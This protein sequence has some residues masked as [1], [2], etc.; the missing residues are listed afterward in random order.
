MT[1]RIH[2]GKQ[3]IRLGRFI[4]SLAPVVMRPDDLI[5]FSKQ[6]YHRAGSVEEW[7]NE[8]VVIGG[9]SPLEKEL[10]EQVP[11]K[12][13]RLLLLGLGG[14]REAIAFAHLGYEVLGVDYLAEMVAK[15]R[16]N[17]AKQ[18][19]SIQSRVQE[20]SRLEMPP[21]TFHLAVLFAAMYSMIPTRRRRVEMLRRIGRSLKPG[22]YL[23]CQF[24]FDDAGIGRR[25]A[26]VRKT[27]AFLTLGNF[28]YEPGDRIWGS[29]FLHAFASFADLESEFA[30]GGFT[31]IY[32]SDPQNSAF[33]GAVLKREN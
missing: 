2:L 5:E 33:L 10:L 1:I 21:H 3:V 19:V 7:G 14:G 28:W 20:I 17:A 27:V 23:L 32:F 22:G 25:F 4:E 16:E 6:R 12:Q 18:G 13:G 11:C 31:V 29:E 8:D 30:A 24:Y 15:A 9:L 26:W